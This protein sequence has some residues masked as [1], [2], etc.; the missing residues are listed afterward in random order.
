MD[1]L[2]TR[3][4]ATAKYIIESRNPS[5]YSLSGNIL[6][7]D[8][9]EGLDFKNKVPFAFLERTIRITIPKDVEIVGD[10]ANRYYNNEEV[11]TPDAPEAPEVAETPEAPVAP[12]SP[13]VPKL[14]QK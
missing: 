13:E 5:I 4:Q 8:H 2:Q 12:K 6:T 10:Y 14:L 1:R 11:V 3:D 9:P 7:L